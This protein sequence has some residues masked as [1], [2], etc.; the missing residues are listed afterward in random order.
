MAPDAPTLEAGNGAAAK[1]RLFLAGLLH[2]TPWHREWLVLPALLVTGVFFALPLLLMAL[3]SLTDPSPINYITIVREPVYLRVLLSTIWMA[4]FVTFVCLLLGYPY[5]YLMH[6]VG[7][8]GK[9]VLALIVLLPFWSS[10]LVRTYAWTILL[11]DTGPINWLLLQAGIVDGPIPLMGNAV[12]TSIGMTHV[13]LP[14]LVLP[15]FAAMRRFD[16][17]L[18]LAASGLGA[19]PVIVF[20]RVF[21]PMSLPGV[22]AG[23]LLTFVLAV[24]F[25]ITPAILGG[26]TAFFSMLIVMEVTRLLQFGFGS[27]L[28]MILLAVVL[29]VVA[30]GSRLVRL[31][32]VFGRSQQ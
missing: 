5:A 8:A 21:F 18:S 20:W 23:C 17:D 15:I 6:R 11:R 13:L 30:V 7:G 1:R 16:P 28:G 22:L 12:G 10:L 29:I 32:D 24:G 31:D 9:W 14:F 19:R 3:R 4:G 27:A 2:R 25:Y 26:R